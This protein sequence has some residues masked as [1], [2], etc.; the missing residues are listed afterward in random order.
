MRPTKLTMKAF[1]SYAGKTEVDFERLT[2]GLYLIVGKTGAGKTTIFDA[3]SFALF[4]VPSGSERKT[5]MLHS[6]FAPLSEDTE[7][8]LDFVHQ[9]R[10]YHVKRSL[11]FQKK[12]GA[13]GYGKATVNAVMTGP[14]QPAIEGATRV[15]ARCEELLGLNSEQFHRIVMLAQGEFREFLK[16]GSDKKNEILGRLFDNSEY[17]RF[18]N[19]LDS[20]AKSLKKQRQGYQT[21]IDTVMGTLFK[22][23]EE[24]AEQEAEGYLPGHPQLVENLQALVRREEERLE[25]LKGESGKLDREAQELTRRE[26]A[27]ET[28]NA[29]LD[30]LDAK[31]AAVAALEGQ[32][33]EFAA[34]KEIY[35]AAE[36]AFHRVKPRENEAERA[37]AVLALTQGEIEK[38]EALQEE[39]DTA[40]KEAQAA[41][42]AEEPNKQR[43]DAL[44]GE[45]AK[46]ADAF[47]RYGQM[48]EKEAEMAE[49]SRTLDDARESVKTT[50]E[51][52]RVFGEALTAIRDELKTLEGCEAEAVRLA[53]ERDA[54]KERFDAVSA[55][56][57]GIAARVDAILAEEANLDAEAGTL[58]QL[59]RYAAE[60][61]NHHHALYQAFLEGQAGL[62]AVSMEKELAETGKTVCPVCN[63]PFCREDAHSFALPSAQVPKKEEVDE[64]ETAAKTAEGERQKKQA[65]LEKRRSLLE[66]RK[67]AT[68]EQT[69]KLAPDCA[70]WGTLVSP[71]WLPALRDRLEQA[72]AEKE[73]ACTDAQAKCRRRKALLADEEDKSAELETLETRCSEEKTRCGELEQEL[74]GLSGAVEE[75]RKQLPYPTEEEAKTTLAAL[76]QE[77]E[78]LLREI[79]ALEAALKDA[80]EA[81][82]RTVGGLRTL[83][84]ALPGQQQ[85]AEKAKDLLQQAVTDNGFTDIG[86]VHAA[87]SPMGGEDGEQWLTA[88]KEA[89]DR[90]AHDL[91]SARTRIDELTAQTEGKVRVDLT[92]L[93]T[94]LAK[95]RSAQSAAAEALAAQTGLLEG[96]RAVADKVGAA[97]AALA[98]TDRAYRRISRLAELAMGTNSEGGKLSFDRYVMGAIF[99]EVLEMANRRLNIMTGG[100]FE[101]IHSV[102]AGRKNA[103]AGL[104]IEVLDVAVGKQR[105]SGSISGGEGF[106]V[107]LSLALG[108]SDVVQSHAGGQ[109]LDTLFIDEGFGTLDD[110]KLDNVIS[111]L[112]QLTEGNRLVGII[113]H[114]DKLEESIP[115][116]LRVM[117]TEH[118]SVLVPE[119][120]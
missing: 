2:G 44:S 69:R 18:Q 55:P 83:Y 105:A 48:A 110:G 3:I 78:K 17:L 71:G 16:A 22:L 90:Y 54:A 58:G 34:R 8:T 28:D 95:A 47:P 49:T 101:L 24:P 119:L 76:T 21:E 35:L 39:Q 107:S 42:D 38:Q 29:L 73:K 45:A 111:V 120:S 108:L 9:G 97:K 23:P 104:E 109:K 37:V 114:V 93:R 117:S 13:E 10:A 6:D 60:A 77:R 5:E 100:R 102:D 75:I 106:M 41:A 64:A 56:E 50:E 43:A 74:R 11:H 116:K 62:I 15:T 94:Q 113:S 115:Q 31:R 98:G 118:G 1:G 84:D 25:T 103:V 12:S 51:Q 27:A 66:Q 86:A 85:M 4:G 57:D 7:V 33:E 99:R 63:T 36:K 32:R 26:G 30:E 79:G 14:E 87:L 88:E 81:L 53:G 82:D 19:L 52:Q 70:S 20:V 65:E 91:T 92:E 67:E 61:E 68:A 59:T 96:H 89:Q 72:L 112:Q 46:L 80:K 40:L